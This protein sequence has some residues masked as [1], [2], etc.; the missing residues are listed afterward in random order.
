MKAKQV[1]KLLS[2]VYKNFIDSINHER[3][4]FIIANRT[5][6]SGGCIPSMLMGEFVNDYDIYFVDP[7][8]AFFVKQYFKEIENN[9]EGKYHVKL[10]TDNAINL[11][12]KIQLITRFSGTP[13]EVTD[14]FDWQHI[15]SYFIFPDTLVLTDD[16]YRL[17]VEKELIYTGSDYPL[18]SLF[19]LKK[20]LKKGWNVSIK[21][22][23]HIAMD[24]VKEFSEHTHVNEDIFKVDVD[25]LIKQLNGR[26]KIMYEE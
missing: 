5:F 16:V 2:G 15:K 9:K 23:T 14:N 18:S 3:V 21:T 4:K 22:M 24:I 17:I 11:S 12:D 8:D 26:N 13:K 10:I 1:E 20:Y 6:V 19:R 25:V 7:N